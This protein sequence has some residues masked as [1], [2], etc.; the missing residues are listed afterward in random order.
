MCEY[1]SLIKD[2]L[3]I[4]DN[5]RLDFITLEQQL[6]VIVVEDLVAELFKTNVIH[7]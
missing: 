2:I 7:Q 3:S 6:L 1:R 5:R 4:I